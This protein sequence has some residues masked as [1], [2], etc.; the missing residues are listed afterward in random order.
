MSQER[1]VAA[2]NLHIRTAFL[3]L[4]PKTSL[5]YDKHHGPKGP[6]LIVDHRGVD[7]GHLEYPTLFDTLA[8]CV[9]TGLVKIPA[10][11]LDIPLNAVIRRH[12]LDHRSEGRL[13]LGK[14]YTIGFAPSDT[15]PRY[16]NNRSIVLFDGNTAVDVYSPEIG[17]DLALLRAAEHRALG[18]CR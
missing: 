2:I 3:W 15:R 18:T 17:I 9:S 14:A 5:Q 11:T 16:D 8:F 10:G 4:G 6:Y 1:Q 7:V 12:L 13:R